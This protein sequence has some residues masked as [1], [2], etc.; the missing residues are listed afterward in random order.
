MTKYFTL[1]LLFVSLVSCNYI[2]KKDVANKKEAYILIGA[3]AS[4]KGYIAKKIT[5]KKK[6]TLHVSTGDLLRKSANGNNKSLITSGKLVSS[7]EIKKMISDYIR[8]NSSYDFYIFDGIP[9]MVDQVEI[10]DKVMIE[11]NIELK[12]VIVIDCDRKILT[13][14]M[15]DRSKKEGRSDDKIEIFEKRISSYEKNAPSIVKIYQDRS[16]DKVARLSCENNNNVDFV[17]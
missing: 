9:R 12:K 4:G 16:F 6:N 14:R 10:L 2:N 3:P 5:E 8:E 15:N 13:K 11:N 1:F 7:A 17:L